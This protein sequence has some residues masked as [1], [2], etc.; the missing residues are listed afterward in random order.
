MPGSSS[1]AG[2]AGNDT[3]EGGAGSD[4]FVFAPGGGEDRILGYDDAADLI[5][6]SAF[7]ITY[8]DVSAHVAQDGADMLIDLTTFGGGVVRV[9]N[10][11]LSS[12]SQDD[13][14]L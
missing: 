3:L 1:L 6:L 10:T 12:L 7:D 14:V 4:T 5:D 2:G 9:E 13:F 11:N 8:S